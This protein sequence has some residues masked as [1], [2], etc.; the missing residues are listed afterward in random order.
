MTPQ[1]VTKQQFRV[2]TAD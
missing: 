1:P 2:N